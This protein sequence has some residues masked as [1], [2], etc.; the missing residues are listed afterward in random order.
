MIKDNPDF[1]ATKMSHKNPPKK[2]LKFPLE[3]IYKNDNDNAFELGEELFAIESRI[4][5]A[6]ENFFSGRNIHSKSVRAKKL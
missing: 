3:K 2:L 4:N 1:D 6:N 5:H